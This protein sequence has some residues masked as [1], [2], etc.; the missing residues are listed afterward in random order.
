MK[1]SVLIFRI[2]CHIYFQI[3]EETDFIDIYKDGLI[4][5]AFIIY[6]KL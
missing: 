6:R 1:C 2:Y 5:K 3:A 4:E